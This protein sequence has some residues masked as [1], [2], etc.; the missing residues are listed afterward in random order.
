MRNF[1]CMVE[2]LKGFADGE[3]LE[4]YEP[5]GALEMSLGKAERTFGVED[6][7]PRTDEG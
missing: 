3:P 7:A 1:L 2:L 4:T 5:L 6:A